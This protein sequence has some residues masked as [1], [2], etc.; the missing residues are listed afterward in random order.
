[1]I[2]DVREPETAGLSFGAHRDRMRA[3]VI[4]TVDQ[5]AAQPMSRIWAKVIFWGRAAAE[6]HAVLQPSGKVA[7]LKMRPRNHARL[8]R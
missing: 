6:L 2:L 4:G 5:D 1:V 7:R 3:M 8:Y